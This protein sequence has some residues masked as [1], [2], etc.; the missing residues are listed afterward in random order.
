[1]RTGGVGSNGIGVRR[2]E[3]LDFRVGGEGFLDD[4][5]NDDGVDPAVLL[6]VGRGAVFGGA[7][8]A[9]LCLMVT[10]AGKGVKSLGS[11]STNGGGELPL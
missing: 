5:D 1:M 8:S 6:E 3:S 11:T 10:Q 4:D 7:N 2:D 9:G